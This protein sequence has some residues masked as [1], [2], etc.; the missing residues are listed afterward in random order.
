[1]NLLQ[2]Y[3]S[4]L[5]LSAIL[6]ISHSCN[7][8]EPIHAKKPS[9]LLNQEQMA[10]ILADMHLFEALEET[11]GKIKD[12]SIVNTEGRYDPIFRKHGVSESD[13]NASFNYYK[14]KP[15][16][17][18]S[19]YASVIQRLGDMEAKSNSESYRINPKSLNLDTV[20]DD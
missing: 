4:Y 6:L 19:I 17:I 5:I 11:G 20:G 2:K 7:R 18:D 8:V 1:M 16:E 12:T 10:A 3:F 14:L 15:V 9:N 13:F